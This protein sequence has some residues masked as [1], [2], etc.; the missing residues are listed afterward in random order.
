MA[1]TNSIQEEIKELMAQKDQME[2]KLMG[3]DAELKAINDGKQY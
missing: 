1:E 3:L 2:V